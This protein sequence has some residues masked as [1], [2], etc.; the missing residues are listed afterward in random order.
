MSQTTDPLKALYQSLN[1]R[2]ALPLEPSDPYYVPLLESTPDKDPVLKLWQ[3][4]DWAQSESVNLLTGFRGNGKSTELRRLRD[5]LQRQSGARVFLVDMADFL[6]MT[7][8]VE[9]SDFVLSL[10]TAL[11]QAVEAETDLKA[12]THGYW[13][14]LQRFLTSD[15]HVESFDLDLQVPGAP[16]KL[17]LK[18][19]NEPDFKQRIQEHL[20]GHLARLIDGAQGYVISLVQAL[21][22]EAQDPDLKVVLLVDSVEQIRGVGA[23]AG[24]VHD[25]V[26]SLFSGQAASLGFPMLHVIYTVP[27]YLLPLAQNLGRTLGGHPIVS[28]PNVHVRHQDGRDDPTGLTLMERIID[29]RHPGWSDIV[30]SPQL[31]RLAKC[32]GGDLR[33]YFRLISECVVT[34]RTARYT[35]PAAGLDDDMVRRVEEQLRN[36]L[37]PIAADDARWLA[38]IHATKDA[39]LPSTGELP[40][41]ARFLDGNLIMNYLNGEPWYDV[42]P[43]LVDAIRGVLADEADH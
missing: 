43:L 34:L 3:R 30:P 37:L 22:K 9:L 16:A 36:E 29:R 31:R 28:W 38:R 13:E 25:S 11:G 18:L 2:G 20:R 7:K 21:R 39:A 35:R 17:G 26:V 5:L 32:S 14:R 15:V 23:D 41:L 8:P 33:D 6:L 40:A 12:L 42:H 4:L 24:K 1:G 27:P 10:M 19:K